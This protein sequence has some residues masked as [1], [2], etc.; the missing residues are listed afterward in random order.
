METSGLDSGKKENQKD[1][2]SGTRKNNEEDNQYE[3]RKTGTLLEVGEEQNNANEKYDI[4]DETNAY[5]D[6]VNDEKIELMTSEAETSES[7]DKNNSGEKDITVVKKSNN[8]K[9]LTVFL[10]TIIMVLF[11]L[12][13]LFIKRFLG[14]KNKQKNKR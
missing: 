9:K 4:S 12:I 8:I 3:N 1:K 14:L 7:A 2:Y 13:F 6:T 10:V 11:L 5:S